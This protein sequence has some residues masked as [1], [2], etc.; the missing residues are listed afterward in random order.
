MTS[1][2][3][4]SASVLVTGA[5]GFIGRALLPHLAARGWRVVAG[6][7]QPRAPAIPG[8]AETRVVGD[9][10]D[11]R[12]DPG[13]ALGGIGAVVHLAG[14]AHRPSDGDEALW[15]RVNT[16]AT[17]RLAE[18]A[19]AAGVRRF[20]FISTARVLGR[21]VPAGRILDHKAP[22]HPADAYARSKAAAEAALHQLHEAGAKGPDEIVPPEIVILRPPL[23]YGPGV[24]ANMARLVA[25]VDRG[26]PLPFA[27]LA[28]RFSL[29]GLTNLCDAITAA[30][31]AP[32]A[33]NRTMLV[34]DKHP[35][36]PP[37]LIRAVACALQ[38]PC[39]LWPCPSGVLRL[40]AVVAGRSAA[41]AGLTGS[42]VLDTAA[43]QEHLAWT[44]E[45]SLDEELTDLA[46]W[47]RAGRPQA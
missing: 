5:T 39:R 23:V 46:A 38:R 35:V 42:F 17:A 11:P 14:L 20:I 32:G 34:A 30:L 26:W 1:A 27:T 31:S 2:A 8:A 9:M 21:S 29:I 24:G 41:M 16:D 22:V 4:G 36:S 12:F 18:A 43:A 3:D 10:A 33:A 13:P 19:G 44:A 15:R 6:V 28:N 25:A 7:R 47:W 40:A 45:R 37:A